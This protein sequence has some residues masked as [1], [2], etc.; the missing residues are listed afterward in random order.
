MT[1]SGRV[2]ER[3]RSSAAHVRSILDNTLDAVIALDGTGRVTF[4][5][6]QAEETFGIPRAA[7]VGRELAVLVLPEE[8][9]EE[10]RGV[11]SSLLRAGSPSDQRLELEAVHAG[12]RRFPLEL[13]LTA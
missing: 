5:N 6:P 13:A 8:A 10:L 11:L 3:R 4:W 7:A 1:S 2:A 12:G 9:R